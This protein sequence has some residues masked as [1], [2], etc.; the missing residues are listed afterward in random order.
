MTCV[1]IKLWILFLHSIPSPVNFP[2]LPPLTPTQR[3]VG[4]TN[5]S[6]WRH[7]V[8]QVYLGYQHNKSQQ[9]VSI[10]LLSSRMGGKSEKGNLLFTFYPN[11]RTQF[12]QFSEKIILC[13][14]FWHLSLPA[15]QLSVQ[16]PDPNLDPKGPVLIYPRIRIQKEY[17]DQDQH[18]RAENTIKL[19]KKCYTFLI[20][21]NAV[22]LDGAKY[23][24]GERLIIH[25]LYL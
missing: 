24:G 11:A 9:R 23:Q 18:P 3:H 6:I 16:T 2:Y 12:A 17:A 22:N 13:L 10:T 15:I 21:Y 25:K 4:K 19:S 5:F 1:N 7:S 20:S 8:E 14:Q